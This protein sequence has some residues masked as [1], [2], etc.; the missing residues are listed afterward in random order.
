MDRMSATE[1]RMAGYA[2]P[3]G[4]VV[5]HFGCRGRD[6]QTFID[7]GLQSSVEVAAD[8]P[9]IVDGVDG[10]KKQLLRVIFVMDI[11]RLLIQQQ[12]IVE[13]SSHHISADLSSTPV[14]GIGKG[15][16]SRIN[17]VL[18]RQRTL[19]SRQGRVEGILVRIDR[20]SIVEGRPM[21]VV[22]HG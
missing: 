13:G 7:H 10:V 14:G 8:S 2:V 12:G 11:G 16:I 3:G 21:A 15:I 6:D 20:E 9:A 19:K 18:I 5:S 4:F 17:D 1:R 22:T